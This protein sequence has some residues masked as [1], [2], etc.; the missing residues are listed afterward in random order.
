MPFA[1]RGEQ[2]GRKDHQRKYDVKL[3][4]RSFV[5]SPER[6]VVRFSV[7]K[8]NRGYVHTDQNVSTSG[9]S[10]FRTMMRDP[11][12]DNAQSEPNIGVGWSDRLRE[13]FISS[14]FN[15][16]RTFLVKERQQY[17]IHPS[18]RDIFRAFQLTPFDKV[19]MVILG[20]DPYHG[21][22]QANGLCFSVPR[23]VPPPPSLK[24]MFAEL[25]R[26]L[27]VTRSTHG[28][29]SAWASQGVLLLNA[30]LT[31]RAE[32][33][34]SHQ[35]RGWEPFTDAAIRALS[36]DRSGLV[37]MLWGRHAQQKATLID[38]QKHHVLTA[39]HPSPLSAHRGF[40]G[41][42]HFRSANDLLSAQGLTPIDWS[43]P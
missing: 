34:G 8:I 40:I 15:D 3:L 41:C 1:T 11:A 2:G 39:P 28:D 18:E 17:T 6:W 29:L 22:G 10:I 33:A 5:Y 25:Q 37:F 7:V 27:G 36:E 26:D 35:G 12:P 43:L 23:G 16:L 13:A 42:G 38:P 4:H 14:A 30:T 20:Q 21:Q 32:Q 19:K 31:V 9:S 24:N